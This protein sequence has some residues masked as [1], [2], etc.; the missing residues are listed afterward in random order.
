LVALIL[1]VVVVLEFASAVNLEVQ[2]LV[3]VGS[4]VADAALSK[5]Y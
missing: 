5:E 1:G 4:T 3:A 2:E